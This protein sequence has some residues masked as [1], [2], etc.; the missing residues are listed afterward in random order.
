MIIF[1]DIDDIEF[2]YKYAI[3]V[4]LLLFVQYISMTKKYLFNGTIDV[5]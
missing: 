2:K 1:K 3:F 4:S 5:V